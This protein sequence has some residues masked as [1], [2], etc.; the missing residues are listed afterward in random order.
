MRRLDP[1]TRLLMMISAMEL[2]D[3]DLDYLG[4]QL[5]RLRPGDLERAC[6]E[7]S[8]HDF[9]LRS[10]TRPKA[11]STPVESSIGD[12]VERLL[13]SEAKLSTSAAVDFVA[14]SLM[15]QGL[16]SLE[17]IPPLSKKSL[18]DWV[19]RLTIKVSPRDL[20]RTATLIR[21]RVAHLAEPDWSSSST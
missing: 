9:Q 5:S 17:D 7:I 6:R 8:R 15:E 13:K 12:R 19:N 18:S 1:M 14:N 16:I 20:L 11:P 10:R 3:R 4:S 21:N 2:S